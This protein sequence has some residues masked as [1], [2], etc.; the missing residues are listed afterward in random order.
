M[1]INVEDRAFIYAVS[2]VVV[3][4]M[5]RAKEGV[6]QRVIVWATACQAQSCTRETTSETIAD[7]RARD[8]RSSSF[9]TERGRITLAAATPQVG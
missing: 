2:G 7:V 5:S 9:E 6:Q 8:M 3:R 1:A 4:P